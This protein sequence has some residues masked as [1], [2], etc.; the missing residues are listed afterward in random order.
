MKHSPGVLLVKTTHQK[1]LAFFLARPSGFFYGSEVSKKT[2]VSIGQVSKILNDLRRAGL[3]EKETKGK[4]ELYRVLT[5]SAVL[6][7]YKVLTTLISIEPLVEGLKKVSRL[8]ILYGSCAKGTNVEESDLDLL[9]VSSVRDKVQDTVARFLY[10]EGRGFSEIK[11]V[12]KRPAAWASL[13]QN[14]PSFYG[15]LQ[16]GILLYEKEID[17]SRL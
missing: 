2:G 6:R 5:D 14:D 11:P 16:K 4:T 9:V 17:E 10:D 15:E 1:V 13:E 8:V 7:T 12:I 3:V